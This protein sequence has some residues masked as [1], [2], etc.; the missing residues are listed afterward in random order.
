MSYTRGAL[1]AEQLEAAASRVLRAGGTRQEVESAVEEAIA[2][3]GYTDSDLEAARV[4]RFAQEIGQL[5][6]RR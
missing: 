1:V 4:N 5:L 6:R 3:Y 2:K